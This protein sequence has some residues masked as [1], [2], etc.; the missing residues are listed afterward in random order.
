M[1]HS[2]MDQ[3]SMEHPTTPD[4][5]QLDTGRWTSGRNALAFAALVSLLACIAGYV[6]NP[7]RFFESYL[8][9]FT[10]TSAIG[11]GA[12]FFVMVQYLTGSAW[13]VVMRRIMENIMITL[14]MGMILFIPLALGLDH[15][16]PWMDR[17][18]MAANPALAAKSGFL[19]KNFFLERTVVY[20][21]LWS[22]WIFSIHRQSVK[23][24]T[25]KSKDQMNAITRWSAPGLFL[26]VVV[27]SI[28]SFD[29]L[30][31]LDP[32]W[33]STIFGLY[34]LADGALGFMAMV[35]LICLGFRKNG[36][37][38][39]SIRDEHY[40]DLGKW[41]FALTCFYTYIAFSQY[42][43][44]WYADLPEETSF[45]RVRSHGEWL[46]WSLALPFI[47][48]FIP[49]FILLCRPVKRKL[50]V[51][52]LLASWSLLVIYLDLYWIVM[53]NFHRE[54]PSF[55]WLDLATLSAT[56]SVCGVVFWGRF[57][58]HKLAPVG[59]LRFEQSLHFENV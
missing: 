15:L 5:Y 26:A 2:V 25:E 46:P 24:D 54:G 16:Y 51:L 58:K 28:A 43:L 41:M 35:T 38:A 59:D 4:T 32:T 7:D 30:M 20:F 19:E 8:V 23:Q 14:P 48:F 31:S 47:R 18:L 33:Y 29:W 36:I 12:F 13:S 9:A 57:K 21:A 50:N 6:T 39:K 40:H 37:L 22:L 1:D 44:I 49:F 3:P 42:I 53:P 34:Y 45:F 55:H 17:A 10:F 52:G 27:G 11:I 56:V